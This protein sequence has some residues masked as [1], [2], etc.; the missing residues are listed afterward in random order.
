M[1]PSKFARKRN[2]NG[3]HTPEAFNE[4]INANSQNQP[5]I[6]ATTD[7]KERAILNFINEINSRGN[8]DFNFYQA[9]QFSL[10]NETVLKIVP[11]VWLIS[12][13]I[14]KRCQISDYGKVRCFVDFNGDIGEAQLIVN[15]W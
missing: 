11:F 1:E 9:T 10:S 7:I 2:A 15:N 5:S 8:D 12:Q 14:M 13:R 4:I 3:G 6:N